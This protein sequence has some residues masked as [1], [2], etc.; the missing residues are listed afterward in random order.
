MDI[1][2]LK[3]YNHAPIISDNIVESVLKEIAVGDPLW[4]AMIKNLLATEPDGIVKVRISSQ[5]VP[6]KGSQIVH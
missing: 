1:G 5:K 3:V 6:E 2:D 4:A